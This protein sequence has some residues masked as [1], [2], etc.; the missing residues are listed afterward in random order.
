MEHKDITPANF[1]A[2]LGKQKLMGSKCKKCGALYLPPRAICPECWG[3]EMEWTEMSGKGKLAAYTCI[4]V[5]PTMMVQEGYGRDNPYCSG[6][7]QTEEGPRI[8]AQILGVDAK[9]PE[10]I[11]I[12]TPMKVEFVER[13]KGDQKKHYLAFRVA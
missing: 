1:N 6:I 2:F 11:K 7:V 9:T 3:S 10:S 5:G 8:S 4:A 13:G 12:G